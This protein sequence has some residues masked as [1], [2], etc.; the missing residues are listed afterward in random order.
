MHAE[1]RIRSSRKRSID[2]HAGREPSDATG[3]ARS[4]RLSLMQRRQLKRRKPRKTRPWQDAVSTAAGKSADHTRELR[5]LSHCA[6]TKAQNS[7][8]CVDGHRAAVQERKRDCV[9]DLT[10]ERKSAQSADRVVVKYLDRKARAPT[11]NRRS[12]SGAEPRSG[13]GGARRGVREY[14]AVNYHKV[15]LEGRKCELDVSPDLAVLP[16]VACAL[17]G[18]RQVR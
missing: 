18:D 15:A 4:E 1:E 14:G 2:G 17:K 10:R 16:V 12:R 3:A 5:R 11:A 6:S 7:G 8:A 9:E 13:V